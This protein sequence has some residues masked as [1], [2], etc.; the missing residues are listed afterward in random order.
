MGKMQTMGPEGDLKIEWDPDNKDEVEAAERIFKEN[1]KK[2][3][4]AFRMYD[5]GKKGKPLDKFDKYA[6]RI[7]FIFPMGGG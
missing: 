2:E 7:L 5:G 3:Y 1:I 4:K 6:E